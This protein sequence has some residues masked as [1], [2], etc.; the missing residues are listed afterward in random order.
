MITLLSVLPF[1]TITEPTCC[2]RLASALAST[3]PAALSDLF[4]VCPR[5]IVPSV[6]T[7]AGPLVCAQKYLSSAIAIGDTPTTEPVSAVGAIT[8]SM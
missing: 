6:I 1:T 2:K 5:T 3:A 4:T 7:E 8:T